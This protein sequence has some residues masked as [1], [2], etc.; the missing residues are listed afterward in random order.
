MPP[1]RIFLY[2]PPM[3]DGGLP[4]F[5][6]LVLDWPRVWRESRQ[7]SAVD[8]L[9]RLCRPALPQELKDRYTAAIHFVE[10]SEANQNWFLPPGA[11]RLTPRDL[12]RR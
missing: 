4:L 12:S 9:T 2:Q 6:D 7:D 8:Y 10:Y 1:D 11:K 5:S 3:K